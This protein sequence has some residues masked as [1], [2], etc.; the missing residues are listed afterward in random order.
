MIIGY[1]N[2]MNVCD[3]L[4]GGMVGKEGPRRGEVRWLVN[5]SGKFKTDHLR[6]CVEPNV[7][8]RL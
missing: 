4:R 7:V 2:N 6:M 1:R 5:G 3:K 8:S